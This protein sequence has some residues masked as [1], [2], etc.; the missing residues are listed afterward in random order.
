MIEDSE[1][2]LALGKIYFT[3]EMIEA[4]KRGEL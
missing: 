3:E 1:K 4:I 2:D